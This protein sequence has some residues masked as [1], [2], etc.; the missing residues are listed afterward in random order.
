VRLIINYQV[1]L[2]VKK[3][4]NL[5]MNFTKSKTAKIFAGVVGLAIALMFVVAPVAKADQTSDLQA[6]INALLATIAAL[7]SQVGGSGGGSMMSHTFS[8][9]LTIGSTGS[10]VTAL[11]TQLVQ[12][13]FLTMPAG[14]AMGYFGSLTAAGVQSWQVSVGLPGT[15][16]FGPMSRAYANSH[17]G[18]TG[19]TTGGT[20]PAGCTSS[21][22]YSSTTGMPCNSGGSL[23]AGCTSSAGFS[24]TTGQSCS[25]TGTTGTVMDGTDGSVTLSYVSYA[26]ASQT[27]KKGDLAKPVISVKLQAVNGQVAVTRF[28][29][30]FSERPWLDFGKLTLTDSTGAVLATKVLSS[31][32]DATEVTVGSDY[33]V[34]FDNVNVNVTPGTDKIL[35]VAVDVLAASDKITGQT[36]YVGIPTGSIRTIN[37]R[38][39]TDSVGLSAT[40]G[41]AANSTYGNAVTL[42]STG[43]SGTIYTRIDP[44]APA[45]DRTVVTSTSQTTP[46]VILGVFG[47]KSQNQSST[48]N[49]LSFNLNTSLGSTGSVD[50]AHTYSNLRVQAG[51][52][53]Y[54]SNALGTTT[55]F[56]NMSIPLA[57]DAWV[58]ITLI[59]DVQSGVNG[60]KA[61]STLLATGGQVVGVD[62]NYNT[63]T[64]SNASNQTSTNNVYSTSGVNITSPSASFGTCPVNNNTTI[65]CDMSM[66]FTVTNVGNSDVFISKTPGVAL[67]TTSG[68]TAVGVTASTTLQSIN[69]A[70]GPGDTT[71]LYDIPSQGSRTFTYSGTFSRTVGTTA[72]YETFQI[73]GINF[74]VNG[75]GT[76]STINYGLEPLFLAR[77]I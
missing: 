64:Y 36:V 61:S 48:I 72:G 41:A 22:G 74:G 38:G 8:T 7:Q 28:D 23:P 32:A 68:P 29:V 70:A 76:G 67:A 75:S 73:T 56:T 27:L 15:G 43:S 30:H 33:L 58:P 16:F 17:W 54:G 1:I 13:G 59:A 12:A 55:T 52:L 71:T 63:L 46:S 18:T 50:A 25:G 37:G 11:Q 20:L 69:I 40:Q 49:G 77:T 65:Q 10:D 47:V 45:T 31:A 62:S 3:I 44:S 6:Q 34:R 2:L 53:T 39:Y 66:S 42:S 19:G 26:P 35:A 14:T 5:F 9:D 60:I 57:Q 51:G 4:I 21:T 24:P